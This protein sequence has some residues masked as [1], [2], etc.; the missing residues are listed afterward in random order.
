MN[1][2]PLAPHILPCS[3]TMVGICLTSI[4]LVKLMEARVGGSHV[5]EYLALNSIIFLGSAFF[6]YLALRTHP[7][8]SAKRRMFYD[9]LADIAFLAGLAVMVVIALL[10]AYEMI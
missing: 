6:A 3:A 7:E 8:L 4:S 2:T 9:T 5:D 10:F 1:R